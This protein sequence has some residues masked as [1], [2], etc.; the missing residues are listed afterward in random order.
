MNGQRGPVNVLPQ[1]PSALLP[2]RV[3]PGAPAAPV[4]PSPAAAP[5]PYRKAPRNQSDEP[6]GWKRFRVRSTERSS[7]R[8]IARG[9]IAGDRLRLLATMVCST[10]T[11]SD[12]NGLQY[13][14]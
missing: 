12:S 3:G 6:K 14:D 2:R 7:A 9:S 4:R 11:T 10:V 13:C 5:L 1:G 8:E